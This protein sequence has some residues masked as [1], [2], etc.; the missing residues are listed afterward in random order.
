[1]FETES[2]DGGVTIGS[3]RHYRRE[4][5][6]AKTAASKSKK[7]SE[8]KPSV[9]VKKAAPAVRK[10]ATKAKKLAG[11]PVV[12]EV[13]AAALVAAA[14]ALKDPA[15]A[16]ALAESAA[17]E[18]QEASRASA[19]KSG[20]FW[21]LAMDIARRSVD[22]LRS[23]KKVAKTAAKQIEKSAKA[24]KADRAEKPKKAKKAKKKSS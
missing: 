23:E 10:V 15:K 12:T 20:A 9:A 21:Q 11:N 14:A 7:A 8:A 24:K 1:M 17:D 16:R 6:M 22:T 2:C 13:V 18:L 3:Q 4:F 19:T 5:I